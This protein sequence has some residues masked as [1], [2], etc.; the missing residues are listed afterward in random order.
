MAPTKH[1]SLASHLAAAV[2]CQLSLAS[3]TKTSF[4]NCISTGDWLN[5]CQMS[6]LGLCIRNERN[7]AKQHV[8]VS[9]F[10]Q[11]IAKGECK[12]QRSS[13]GSSVP[14]PKQEHAADAQIL[15]STPKIWTYPLL[16]LKAV[17][18]AQEHLLQGNQQVPV[19]HMAFPPLCSFLQWEFSYC[20]QWER[21]CNSTDGQCF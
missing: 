5:S 12:P 8:P 13:E 1:Y 21:T 2:A 6:L 17:A 16:N 19:T 9:A 3:S 14:M 11:L 18:N 20:F 15:P 4:L 7:K 10:L